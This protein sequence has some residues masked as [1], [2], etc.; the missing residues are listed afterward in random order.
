MSSCA[1]EG[2]FGTEASAILSIR[3]IRHFLHK[4]C[5]GTEVKLRQ[6]ASAQTSFSLYFLSSSWLLEICCAGSVESCRGGPNVPILCKRGIGTD[7]Q[8][9]QR[10]SARLC[11]GI[12]SV[13]GYSGTLSKRDSGACLVSLLSRH[14]TDMFASAQL[15][16]TILSEYTW[17]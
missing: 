5:L 8:L 17:L 13:F 14:G 15:L 12:A 10:T 7:I 4:I 3:H 16:G 9:R 1:S 6:G 11:L 2:G